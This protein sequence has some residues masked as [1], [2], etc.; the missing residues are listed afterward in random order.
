MLETNDLEPP[1]VV[2]RTVVATRALGVIRIRITLHVVH[3]IISRD[4]NNTLI[5]YFSIYLLFDCFG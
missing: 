3:R 5:I 2:K 4:G 1:P